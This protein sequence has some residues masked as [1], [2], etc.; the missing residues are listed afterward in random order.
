[1]SIWGQ[2]F[3]IDAKVLAAF[4][5]SCLQKETSAYEMYQPFA[6]Y[7]AI[8]QKKAITLGAT[9]KSPTRKPIMFSKRFSIWPFIEYCYYQNSAHHPI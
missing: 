5:S 9:A 7:Q 6:K 2:N 4:L 1:M 8:F 3:V